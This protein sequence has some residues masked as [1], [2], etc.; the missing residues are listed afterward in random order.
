[1]RYQ[2]RPHRPDLKRESGLSFATACRGALIGAL[3][4]GAPRRRVVAAAQDR[5]ESGHRLG[6]ERGQLGALAVEGDR[7]RLVAEHL[8]D[9]PGLVSRGQLEGGVEGVPLI[10]RLICGGPARRTSAWNW[11][12]RQVT[13]ERFAWSQKSK[14]VVGAPQRTV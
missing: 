3:V 13:P 14:V 6:V 10:A 4:A 12:G 1:M 8:A 2:S 11:R 7:D 5:V 9:N